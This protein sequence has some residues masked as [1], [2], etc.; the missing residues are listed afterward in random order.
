MQ[1]GL[2]VWR[3][4]RPDDTYEVQRQSLKNSLLLGE[5]GLFVLFRP[6]TDWIRSTH[7]REDTLFY[8]KVTNLNVNHVTKHPPVDT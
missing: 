8:P 3:P 5:A 2:V 1:S 6:S 4:R 7:N